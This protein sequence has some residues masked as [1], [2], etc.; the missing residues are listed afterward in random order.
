MV[1]ATRTIESKHIL[2]TGGAGFIGSHL[3][4]ALVAEG[5]RRVT[6]IDNLYLGTPANLVEA[7]HNLPGLPILYIDASDARA[8]R[9]ALLDL[10]P[11]DVVFNVAAI[12]LPISL[13]QPQYCF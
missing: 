2:V 4:D 5:A 1:S 6:V 10:G 13:E 8:M 12:P 9:N 11:I 7:R 3:I